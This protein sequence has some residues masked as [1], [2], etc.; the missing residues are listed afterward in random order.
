MPLR[1]PYS[2]TALTGP[3]DPGADNRVHR[4]CKNEEIVRFG[5]APQ[6]KVHRT[7]AGRQSKVERNPKG[8]R[9]RCGHGGSPSGSALPRDPPR[10]ETE[11]PETG[12]PQPSMATIRPCSSGVIWGRQGS[13]GVVRG[14]PIPDIKSVPANPRRTQ[15]KGGHPKMPPFAL[16]TRPSLA[17]HPS[18][19][20]LLTNS[21]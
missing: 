1:T 13:S 15:Q 4:T 20:Y 2:L 10:V 17:G 9:R 11:A 7:L 3:V 14:R 18:G 16:N 19:S 21:G 8:L 6:R 12:S 5:L